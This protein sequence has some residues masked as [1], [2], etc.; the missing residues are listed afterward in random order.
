MTSV[1]IRPS[2]SLVLV[3]DVMATATVGGRRR[4]VITR[5][6]LIYIYDRHFHCHHLH[7]IASSFTVI[8][9]SFCPSYSVL[10]CRS[11][12][13]QAVA[14]IALIDSVADMKV[15]PV[16]TARASRA[17]DPKKHGDLQEKASC[18]HAAIGG[19]NCKVGLGIQIGT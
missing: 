4:L 12:F 16:G 18:H 8:R 5:F 2:P 9:S 15:A 1:Q 7:Y 17:P 10:F 14:A 11:V 19:P 3:L 6:L 13:A